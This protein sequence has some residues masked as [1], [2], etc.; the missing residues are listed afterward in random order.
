MVGGGE[1]TLDHTPVTGPFG[2]EIRGEKPDTGRQS[3]G[4]EEVQAGL[5]VG[6]G[7]VLRPELRMCRASDWVSEVQ[8]RN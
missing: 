3:S 7:A 4:F 8:T 1:R 5:T 6:Q 2:M